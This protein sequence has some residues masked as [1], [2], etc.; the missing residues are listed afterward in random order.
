MRTAAA[1]DAG[2]A[3]FLRRL[4]DLQRVRVLEQRLGGNAAPDEAG[5]AERL[6]LLDD[7]HLQAQ[8][9]GANGRHVAARAGA[10]H[11]DVVL[12]RQLALQLQPLT[13][14]L[15]LD[16]VKPT[17]ALSVARL[18]PALRMLDSGDEGLLD[19]RLGGGRGFFGRRRDRLDARLQLAVFVLELPVLLG[20]AAPA[21]A[22][23]AAPSASAA[24]ASSHPLTGDEPTANPYAAT[25]ILPVG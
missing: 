11:D 6:L 8:L 19:G 1:V 7:G 18:K 24:S 23:A 17:G 14:R 22:R 9:R 4:R 15:E 12:V 10:D 13:R 3:P 5:A 20:R 25:T 16:S 21:G 2:Q